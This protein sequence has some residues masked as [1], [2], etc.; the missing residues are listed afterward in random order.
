MSDYHPTG[1]EVEH[2]GRMVDD[3]IQNTFE[4]LSAGKC[5]Y[6]DCVRFDN[7][8]GLNSGM[9]YNCGHPFDSHLA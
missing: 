6:C 5:M 4:Q 9:D 2:A 8:T 7:T 3:A 1:A